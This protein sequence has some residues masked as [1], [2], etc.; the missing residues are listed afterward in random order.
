M[1]KKIKTQKKKK[2]GISLFI[3]RIQPLN[4]LKPHTLI[5]GLPEQ[6]KTIYINRT[7]F[8]SFSSFFWGVGFGQTMASISINFLPFVK[9]ANSQGQFTVLLA[10]SSQ[11]HFRINNAGLPPHFDSLLNCSYL[12]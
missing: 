8:F 4:K 1:L 9:L 5:T 6:T 7:V 12:P 2:K 11:P 10:T 3:E